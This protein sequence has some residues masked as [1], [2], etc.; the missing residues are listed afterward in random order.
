MKEISKEKLS[1]YFEVT[2]TALR[3]AK[4]SGNRTELVN[5]R[6]DFLDMIERYVSDAKHFEGKEDY[7]N[8]FAALNYAHGWLDAGARLGIFDVHNSTFFTVDDKDE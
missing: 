2:E 5:Q 1:K 4:E 7:V 3:M 6:E 8:A